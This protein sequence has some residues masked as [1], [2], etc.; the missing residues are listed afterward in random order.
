MA[1]DL[2]LAAQGGTCKVIGTECCSYISDATSEVMDMMHDT[3]QG[4]RDLD[5][6]H[7]FNLGDFSGVFGSWGSGLIKFLVTVLVSLVILLLVISCLITIGK[8]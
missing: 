2:L 5:E 1:F 7:G 8:H 4:I 6:T 3:A